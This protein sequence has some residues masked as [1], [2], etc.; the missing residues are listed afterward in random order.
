LARHDVVI[1]NGRKSPISG[2]GALT[3]RAALGRLASPLLGVYVV[4]ARS[5]VEAIAPRAS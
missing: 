2:V 5:V 1:P 4:A 3:D